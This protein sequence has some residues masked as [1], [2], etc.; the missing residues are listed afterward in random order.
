MSAGATAAGLLQRFAVHGR[1]YEAQFDGRPW[2]LRSRLEIFDSG[3]D[4]AG[5]M[6][7]VP[8]L[9]VVMMNP[10]ASRPL[11]A[12]DA[13][14]WGPALP[15]RTQ[16]QLMK[17]ALAARRQGWALR[18]IR[19]LNLSDLRTPKSAELF[20]ALQALA[21]DRHSI[22][23]G[24]RAGE[25]AQALGPPSVPVLRA[26]GLA[27]ALSSLAQLALVATASRQVLGLTD[28]GLSYRHPLPQRADLQQAWLDA[29]VR[30]VRALGPVGAIGAR[31]ASA[32]P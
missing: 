10:G 19:V 7:G 29:M 11:G 28:N 15:D 2:R 5:R 16:Y 32:G 18:H 14:G 20:A 6:A 24:R 8:D 9:V 26:W 22:F 30:Q 12:L 21:D 1:F 23:C 17:L 3:L 4:P 25:L 27:P 31:A 13:A